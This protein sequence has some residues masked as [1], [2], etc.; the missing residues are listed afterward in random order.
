MP[1]NLKSGRYLLYLDILGFS[2]LVQNKTTDEVY[3]ILNKA[4]AP[5]EDWKTLN[6]QF[7]T[8]HFSDSFI[9]YQDKPGYGDWAFLDIYAI[10]GM[11]FSALLSQG[12][13]VRGTISFGEFEYRMDQSGNHPIYFGRA[14]IEAYQ[15][16]QKEK[17]I[18]ITILP[19]AWKPYK[20]NNPG[21][22]PDIGKHNTWGSQRRDEIVLLNPFIKLIAYYQSDD[23][24]NDTLQQS[25][26]DYLFINDIKA[27]IFLRETTQKYR[28]Q[29][30]FSSST[31]VKYHATSAFLDQILGKSI[32]DWALSVFEFLKKNSLLS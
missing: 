15:A 8:I 16:E 7:K 11:L 32:I 27:F 14:F 9:L 19:S 28:E 26:L 24:S 2:E 20:K 21:S 13:A 1:R 30:E 4:L 31:A 12:L 6:S 18:G 23:F 17:W 5:F 22:I 10:G 25:T 3:E 29:G